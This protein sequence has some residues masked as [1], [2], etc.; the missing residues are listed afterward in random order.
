[1]LFG[2]IIYVGILCASITYLI[3]V[4]AI[5]HGHWHGAIF[6]DNWRRDGFCISFPGTYYNSHYLAFY[7]DAVFVILM[8]I[9]V[10]KSRLS[11][12]HPA[13]NVLQGHIPSLAAHA[14]AHLALPSLLDGTA[15]MSTLSEG[16]TH[17]GFSG[18]FLFG[19]FTNFIRKPFPWTPAFVAVQALMHAYAACFVVPAIYLAVYV[20]LVYNFNL[21]FFK[22]LREPRHKLYA[23]EALVHRLPVITM[24]WLEPLL[25]DSVLIRAGGHLF[26]DAMIPVSAITFF[27]VVRNQPFEPLKVD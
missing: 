23:T 10:Q 21:C 22:L 11:R 12:D 24:T 19:F 25:C 2:D 15:G 20:G 14:V 27:L 8:K 4:M 1:M 17:V 3:L 6:G 9:I 18:L 13:I 26:F 7:A 5:A 16:G